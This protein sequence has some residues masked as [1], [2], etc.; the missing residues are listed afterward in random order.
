MT[1]SLERQ[2]AKIRGGYDGPA[3]RQRKRV[4][5]RDS[6]LYPPN[7][8]AEIDVQTLYLHAITGLDVLIQNDIRLLPFRNSLF[9]AKSKDFELEMQ[10]PDIIQELKETITSFLR[11][12]SPQL[13][14]PSAYEVFYIYICI[15]I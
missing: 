11:M 2:M 6:I 4:L 8:A 15:C 5:E 3:M 13:S 1:S 9:S 14:N 10:T 7:K 12:V